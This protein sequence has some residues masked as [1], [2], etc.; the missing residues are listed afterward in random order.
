MPGSDSEK[1][2][3]YVEDEQ[4]EGKVSAARSAKRKPVILL[5]NPWRKIFTYI[6]NW[7]GLLTTAYLIVLFLTGVFL[8]HRLNMVRSE[9]QTY[10]LDAQEKAA[11]Q[12]F[13]AA[14]KQL[15]AAIEPYTK[16]ADYETIHIQRDGTADFLDRSGGKKWTFSVDPSGESMVWGNSVPTQPWNFLNKLHLADHTHP[17]WVVLSTT[18]SV[19]IIV[20]LLTGLLLVRWKP[21]NIILTLA[22]VAVMVLAI[23]LYAPNPG[24]APAHGGGGKGKGKGKGKGTVTQPAAPIPKSEIRIPSCPTLG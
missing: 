14:T 20:V 19:G 10:T 2:L 12:R 22:G 5:K 23:G 24:G 18:I 3:N 9:D 16:R 1:L 6:H 11:A 8:N 7:G 21:L 13:D 4:A 17:A 15:A